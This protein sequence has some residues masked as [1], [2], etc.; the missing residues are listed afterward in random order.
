LIC[1][2]SEYAENFLREL[3]DGP[4][5]GNFAGNIIA[6][7]ILRDYYYWPTLFRD[8]HTYIRKCKSFQMS[9]GRE[10]RASIPLQPITISIPLEQWGLDVIREITPRSSKQH[11]YILTATNY[12]TKW[13]EA[14]PMTHMN[15]KVLNQFI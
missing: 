8:S 13:A 12:F 4:A 15:E 3:H 1:I 5:G 14:I 2:E 7:K 10:K 6:N 11:K 9:T